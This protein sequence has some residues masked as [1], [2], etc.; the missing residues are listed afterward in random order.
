MEKTRQLNEEE[1]DEKEWLRIA[2][3]NLAFDSLKE[4]EEDIY[5][6]KDGRPFHDDI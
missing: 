6:S 3:T 1:I 5:T 4:P 2:N